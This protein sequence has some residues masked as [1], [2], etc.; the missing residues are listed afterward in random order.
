MGEMC[1][2][3]LFFSVKDFPNIV[4]IVEKVSAEGQLW[5]HTFLL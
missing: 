3:N 5:Q 1:V 4:Q 2:V